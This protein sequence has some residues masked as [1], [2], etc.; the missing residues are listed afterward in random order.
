MAR[1]PG[2]Y[3]VAPLATSHRV[4]LTPPMVPTGGGLAR[5]WQHLASCGYWLPSS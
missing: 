1:V 4:P 2:W 5:Q 3:V